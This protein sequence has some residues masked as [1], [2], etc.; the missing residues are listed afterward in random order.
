M[1]IKKMSAIKICANTKF[2]LAATVAKLEDN[3]VSDTATASQSY[4]GFQK[5]IDGDFSVE[6]PQWEFGG[7]FGVFG[8][9]SGAVDL[10]LG[11]GAVDALEGIGTLDGHSS[12]VDVHDLYLKANVL[13]GELRVAMNESLV[14][15]FDCKW[16]PLCDTGHELPG[17]STNIGS[18]IGARHKVAIPGAGDLLVG[19]FDDVA[20]VNAPSDADDTGLLGSANHRALIGEYCHNLGAGL[21]GKSFGDV[22]LAVRAAVHQN[23]ASDAS[24]VA[25][26]NGRTENAEA[27]ILDYQ[28]RNRDAT[29]DRTNHNERH[30]IVEYGANICIGESC[31]ENGQL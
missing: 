26:N 18:V 11:T 5:E 7:S 15:Q 6:A 30:S 14:D 20:D 1:G 29:N 10:A 4:R 9:G 23:Q 13:R 19:V 27:A 24:N 3:L 22:K 16:A 31:D 17:L 21:C 25:L 2:A 28:A 8:D 12:G